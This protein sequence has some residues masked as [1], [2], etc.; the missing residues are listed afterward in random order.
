MRTVFTLTDL[1]NIIENIFNGN[2]RAS[3]VSKGTIPYENPNSE[4]IGLIDEDTGNRK[5]VD[6]ATYLNIHFY[7]WKDRLVS[8]GE[9]QF[10]EDYNEEEQR[11][12]VLEDWVQSLNFSMNEAYAL[13]EKIDSEVVASQDIDSA[14]ITGRITFLI[15][16]DKISNLDYYVSKIRNAFL[17]NPQ[18]IQNAYGD[19]IKAYLLLGDLIYEQ[20][21]FMTQLG[22]TIIV[23]SNFKLAYLGSALTYNDTEIQISLDGDDLYDAEG[24]IV[25]A[26]GEPTE[27]K[28]LTMPITKATWQNIFTTSPLSTQNRPDLTGYMAQALSN[29]KTL[30]FYDFNKPLT[31]KFNDLF[32][33]CSCVRYDGKI[34]N[35]KN[36]N[37]PVYFRIISNGHSYVYHDI[38]D[39]MQKTITNN[40][41]NI[42]SITTKGWGK[43]IQPQPI[44]EV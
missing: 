40:D 29:V 9:K 11:L 44:I 24:N 14:T 5:D 41:F 37:I 43:L 34:E 38:I 28:Y 27:T 17:G 31:M 42:S 6:L 25:N 19:I 18:E 13:V 10:R 8:V 15:Q 33:R 36:V 35:V 20:E 1:R 12:S 22:E 3:Q 26:D 4:I 32:W 23:A 30:S 21:P 16:T 2:L 39:N 7:K